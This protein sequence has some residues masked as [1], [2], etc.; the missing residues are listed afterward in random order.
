MRA[1]WY[2]ETDLPEL[3]NRPFS[4]HPR[5]EARKTTQSS[6][7][8]DFAKVSKAIGVTEKEISR[9]LAALK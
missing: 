7:D 9:V 2:F 4:I 3:K 1:L 8:E 5:E 6:T